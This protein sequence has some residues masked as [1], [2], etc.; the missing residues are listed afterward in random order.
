[1]LFFLREQLPVLYD[2]NPRVLALTATLLPIAAAFQL[3]DG[4]HV[5]AAGVLRGMGR[6]AILPILHFVSF[7]G[8]GLP[9]A[10]WLAFRR[11]MGVEG[12]WWGLGLGL[13]VVSAAL[14]IWLLRRGPGSRHFADHTPL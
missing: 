11:G 9:V 13:A 7:Y 4:L 8:L 3:F 2:A 14:L 12:V 1:V 6:T 5:V 10:W